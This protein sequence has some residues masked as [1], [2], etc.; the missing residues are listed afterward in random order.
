MRRFI[1]PIAAILLTA[2]CAGSKPQPIPAFPASRSPAASSSGAAGVAKAKPS[3]SSKECPPTR[4]IIVWVKV[5]DVPASA[6]ELGNYN[7]ATCEST[8]TWLEQTSP[9]EAGDCLEA[10]WASDNPGYNVD[11]EPAPRLKKVQVAVGPAC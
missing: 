5:P 9:K 6:Q 2:A 1:L 7:A 4:D 8:F 11:A 10:A 3:A